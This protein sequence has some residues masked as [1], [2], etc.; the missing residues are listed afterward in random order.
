MTRRALRILLPLDGSGAAETILG[1]VLPLGQ[2]RPLQLELLSVIP[3]DS[4]RHSMES[5]L[6]KAEEALKHSGIDVRAGTCRGI[7]ACAIAA[8]AAATRPDMIAMTTHGRT[9]LNR[10]VMGSVTEEVLR[11][12][13]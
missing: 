4:A 13:P 5:Y 8:H 6:A 11:H 10:L 2:R 7:P 12:A 1:A 9:G 3:E